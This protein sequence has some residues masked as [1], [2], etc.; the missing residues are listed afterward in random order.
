VPEKWPIVG[1]GEW[2]DARTARINLMREAADRRAAD[3]VRSADAIKTGARQAFVGLAFTTALVRG[4]TVFTTEWI[5]RS[6]TRGR[7]AIAASMA[8]GSPERTEAATQAKPLSGQTRAAAAAAAAG[9]AAMPAMNQAMEAIH[10]SAT[11]I[12][13]ILKSIGESAFQTD[14]LAL[15]AAGAAARARPT[16]G[17]GGPRDGREVCRCGAELRPRRENLRPRVGTFR[18]DRGKGPARRRVGGRE[19]DGVERT[20]PGIGQVHLAVAQMDTVTQANLA[21]TEEIATQAD[22]PNAHAAALTAVIGGWL[23]LI[24]GARTNDPPGRP[25]GPRAGATSPR[26]GRPARGRG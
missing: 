11:T 6:I 19:G 2:F 10:G 17:A 9:S 1:A 13:K 22:E 4:F 7:L 15:N 23:A 8:D 12:A 18:R 16:I 20:N 24:G 21:V 14:L 5:V 3:D 26:P 25:G